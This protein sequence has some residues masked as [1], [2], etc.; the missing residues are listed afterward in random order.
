MQSLSILI[1]AAELNWISTSR[2]PGALH[3]AGFEVTVLAP[4]D[5]LVTK[6][7]Y[8]NRGLKRGLND[9]RSNGWQ[10]ERFGRVVPV[11]D[12]DERKAGDDPGSDD[13]GAHLPQTLG[14]WRSV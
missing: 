5:A 14:P 8:V 4:R 2:M 6:S 12:H 3:H 11:R 10:W 13:E 9:W 7:R 1:V